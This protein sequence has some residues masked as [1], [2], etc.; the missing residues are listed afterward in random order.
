M[1][2]LF[3]KYSWTD[4]RNLGCVAKTWNHDETNPKTDL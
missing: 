1:K 4:E 2:Q 3:V